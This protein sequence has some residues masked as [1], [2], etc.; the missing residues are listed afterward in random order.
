VAAFP[1]VSS[2]FEASSA[3]TGS[4]KEISS[5]DAS[6]PVFAFFVRGMGFSFL[7]FGQWHDSEQL[8]TEESVQENDVVV[9]SKLAALAYQLKL[10]VVDWQDRCWEQALPPTISR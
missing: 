8:I 6:K 1:R 3:R 5:R 10:N 7:L 9:T 2:S 4:K